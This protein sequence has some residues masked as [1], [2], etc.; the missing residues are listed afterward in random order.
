MWQLKQ[1]KHKL[2]Y[3]WKDANYHTGV[4]KMWCAFKAQVKALSILDSVDWYLI[5]GP[6][7]RDLTQSRFNVKNLIR[8]SGVGPQ[9]TQSPQ[10][11]VAPAMVLLLP[12]LSSAMRGVLPQ[13]TFSRNQASLKICLHFARRHRHNLETIREFSFLWGSLNESVEFSGH[14]F[15]EFIH[16]MIVFQCIFFDSFLC[17]LLVPVIISDFFF[18]FGIHLW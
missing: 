13:V 5:L 10:L 12:Y 14:Y 3:H 6:R 4:S 16:S 1:S 15:P 9:N 18:S 17:F 8:A 11:K 2:K 7:W